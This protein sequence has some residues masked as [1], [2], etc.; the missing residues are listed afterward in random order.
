[1]RKDYD[2]FVSP[3]NTPFLGYRRTL[4]IFSAVSLMLNCAVLSV[5]AEN[6]RVAAVVGVFAALVYAVAQLADA[7]KEMWTWGYIISLCV[8][9]F[10]LSF[11]MF[12]KFGEICLYLLLSCEVLIFV[13]LSVIFAF[14][15]R[16]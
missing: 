2:P 5:I 1:M 10:G 14:Q 8:I 9:F 15:I 4:F 12:L 11:L 6:M 3:Q 13:I 16:R 7:R